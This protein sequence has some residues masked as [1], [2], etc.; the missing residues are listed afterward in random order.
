M[1]TTIALDDDV[2][3]AAQHLSRVS[4]ERL[5]KVISK[6]ARQGLMRKRLCSSQQIQRFPTFDVPAGAP[7]ISVSHIDRILHMEGFP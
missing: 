7:I 3:A 2:Y 6:L 5:G 1:R 4:G